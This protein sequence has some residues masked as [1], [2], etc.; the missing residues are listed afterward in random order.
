MLNILKEMSSD[1]LLDRPLSL[2][3]G[4]TSVAQNIGDMKNSGIEIDLGIDIIQTSEA[5]LGVNFNT[6]TLKN[7]IT[8]LPEPI[9]V[10][11]KKREQGRDFQEYFL[12][13]WAGV[14]PA[15]GDPLWYL[16]NADGTINYNSTT[17]RVGET[18]RV[19]ME[20]KSATPDFY[21]GFNLNASYK[22]F[23]LGMTFNYSFG[24]YLYFNPGWVIH[25]DGRFTPRSTTTY[26]FNN[27]WTTP[28]QNG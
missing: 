25:G 4:F 5:F 19:Y 12:F 7:E 9:V 10:S 24:N 2:T 27:R 6:T 11:T 14:D 8:Y 17:N 21:G 3:T 23:S 15:N 1:L 13:P 20:G 26:A 16:V 18:E 28:G 22:S